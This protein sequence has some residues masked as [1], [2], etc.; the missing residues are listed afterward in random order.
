MKCTGVF[1]WEIPIGAWVMIAPKKGSTTTLTTV[2]LHRTVV[3]R[4]SSTG[5]RVVEQRR[6]YAGK[7]MSSPCIIT[8]TTNRASSL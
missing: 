6:L 2:T 1:P 5:L 8:R 3:L 7:S 4:R